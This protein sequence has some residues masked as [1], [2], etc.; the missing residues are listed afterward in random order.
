MAL[1]VTGEEEEEDTATC[2]NG[3]LPE[4]DGEQ[5]EKH[6]IRGLGINAERPTQIISASADSAK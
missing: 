6:S 4:R 3:P 1:S 5:L 2:L